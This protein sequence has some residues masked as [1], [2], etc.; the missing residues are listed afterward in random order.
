MSNHEGIVS[1]AGLFLK[2]SAL[3]NIKEAGDVLLSIPNNEMIH[4]LSHLCFEINAFSRQMAQKKC[5]KYFEKK[6]CLVEDMDDMV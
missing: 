4:F 1:S 2:E 3:G 5:T 6:K